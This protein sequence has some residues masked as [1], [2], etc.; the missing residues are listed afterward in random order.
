MFSSRL[1]LHLLEDAYLIKLAQ[2]VRRS[3]Y[4]ISISQDHTENWDCLSS[5]STVMFMLMSVTVFL[6]CGW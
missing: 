5:F 2:L 3:Q 6:L 1:Q 4:Q